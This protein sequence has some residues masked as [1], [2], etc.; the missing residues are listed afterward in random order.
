VKGDKRKAEVFGTVTVARTDDGVAAMCL[1]DNKPVNFL[2]ALDPDVT[3]LHKARKVWDGGKMIDQPYAKMNF[4]ENYNFNMN[5]VDRADQLRGNYR[6]DGKWN[7]N[8]KWWWALF[9]WLLGISTTNAYLI[10]KDVYE[11]AGKKTLTHRDFQATLVDELTKEAI[12]D[13]NLR[14]GANKRSRDSSGSSGS[15]ETPK[16][17]KIS[18]KLEDDERKFDHGLHVFD[19]VGK[20]QQCQLCR[21][22]RGKQVKATLYCKRCRVNLC[23]NCWKPFHG[24]E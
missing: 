4:I 7:R 15:S 17:G 12:Q 9:L 24:I 18:K 10:Y 3:V 14:K 19:L 21:H 2:S 1:Y 6:P 11:K 22:E 23:L 8:R 5:S 13:L 16:A 20:G